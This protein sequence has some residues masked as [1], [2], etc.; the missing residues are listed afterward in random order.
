MY[1]RTKDLVVNP[2]ART[3]HV[4]DKPV[5]LTNKEFDL[6]TFFLESGG[7]A[8]SKEQ[9]LQH[10]WNTNHRTDASVKKLVSE[11]RKKIGD[12]VDEPVYIKTLGREGYQ[13]V[14]AVETAHENHGGHENSKPILVNVNGNRSQSLLLFTA[15]LL[16]ILACIGA[17]VYKAGDKNPETAFGNQ[18]LEKI[19]LPTKHIFEG[20][21]SPDMNF[22]AYSE[23]TGNGYDRDLV[24]YDL[25]KYKIHARLENASP[26]AWSPTSS[27]I[28]YIDGSNGNCQFKIYSIRKNESFSLNKCG[29]YEHQPSAFWTNNQDEVYLFF[30]EQPES[31]I[32]LFKTNIR[33]GVP[34]L[35]L[36]C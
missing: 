15:L 8:F 7:Q 17:F 12:S 23:L 10:V 29:N 11:L 2:L 14:A 1:I 24:I 18:Y 33:S 27:D 5:D 25:K 19:E 26:G 4:S 34:P 28:V 9:I 13:W 6:L 20:T 31:Q 21:R 36:G 30:S 3:L 16:S 22:L 35:R 32:K